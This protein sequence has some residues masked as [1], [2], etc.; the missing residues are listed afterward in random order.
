MIHNKLRRLMLPLTVVVLTLLSACTAASNP[1]ANPVDRHKFML[2]A[3][4]ALR[5]THP[6]YGFYPMPESQA[7]V[8]G[9]SVSLTAYPIGSAMTGDIDSLPITVSHDKISGTVQISPFPETRLGHL[10][11]ALGSTKTDTPAT[12]DVQKHLSKIGS[13]VEVTAVAELI[14]PMTETEIWRTTPKLPSP[15]RVLFPQ[16][17]AGAPLGNSIFCERTCNKN[18][19][20][21]SF[22]E[23]VSTLRPQDGPILRAFGVTIEELKYVAQDGKISGLIYESHHSKSLLAI[24]RHPKVKALHLVDVNLRCAS[25]RT[26]N[27][28]PVED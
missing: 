9:I 14:E 12:E 27:C 7:T 13:G 10:L 16:R 2:L 26:A 5:V 3:E 17:G 21:S 18:S 22:Q 6:D 24:S 23:W 15:Q 4:N 19:Y 11:L 25:D 28:Q 8:S 1:S 20:V